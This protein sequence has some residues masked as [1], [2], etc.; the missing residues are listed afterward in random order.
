M[1]LK[2]RLN[3]IESKRKR[4]DD[5]ELFE[6]VTGKSTSKSHAYR[7]IRAIL[8][9]LDYQARVEDIPSESEKYLPADIQEEHNV[10]IKKDGSQESNLI[11]S[12]P[13]TLEEAKEKAKNEEYLLK[14][15]GY[16]PRLWR[17]FKA[18][19]S[20]W[21]TQQ[22]GGRILTQFSSR[23]EVK[24]IRD[25]D[26]SVVELK[27]YIN[28]NFNLKIDTS[29]STDFGKSSKDY[30]VEISIFDVHF[31]RLAYAPDTG[32]DYNLKE[33][34]RRFN[35]IVDDFIY[36]LNILKTDNNTYNIK[37][38]VFPI[39]ND[40]FHVD[41]EKNTTTL[42]TPQTTDVR[43]Q[44]MY[45]EGCTLL[46]QAALKLS[47]IAPV[48]IFVIPGNHDLKMSQMLIYTLYAFLK[49]NPNI[50]IHL[51]TKLRKYVKFGNSVV[52]FGHG[53]HITKKEKKSIMQKEASK[54]FGDSVYREMHWGH[55]HHE[56]IGE[57]G[58]VIHRSLDSI[59]EAGNWSYSKGFIGSVKRGYCF[60]WHKEHGLEMLFHSNVKR[61]E[62]NTD[63]ILEIE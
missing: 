24:P 46:R 27:E 37:K 34:K 63:N 22:K 35:A 26:I 32:R 38:I 29:I 54:A 11:I 40:F 15:H 28:D 2:E 60:V 62:K 9:Y 14:E 51:D 52:G 16:D 57:E 41:N 44:E 17:I 43:W 7:K 47:E 42:G 58:G 31:N 48:E 18:K 61:G 8:D 25:G 55:I 6:I 56:N 49:N 39:G 45:M 30:L 21:N 23:V 3:F 1:N 36:K 10:E 53:R 12:I 4:L 20:R 19:S 50:K 33:A 13:A 5:D 59:D